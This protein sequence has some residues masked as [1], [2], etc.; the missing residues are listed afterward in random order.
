M[1]I[2]LPKH[3][4]GDVLPFNGTA[5]ERAANILTHAW[6]QEENP[7]DEKTWISVFNTPRPEF[8]ARCSKCKAVGNMTATAEWPCGE[9]RLAETVV[10]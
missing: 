8:L 10:W 5:G 2:R 7:M 1:T 4:V 6:E 9:P 3:L